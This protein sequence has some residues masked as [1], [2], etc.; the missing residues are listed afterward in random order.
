MPGEYRARCRT[1]L[2]PV[3]F[4][5]RVRCTRPLAC[6]MHAARGEANGP[7][8]RVDGPPFRADATAALQ[9][10]IPHWDRARSVLRRLSQAG[11]AE[12]I[13]AWQAL[14]RNTQ[15]QGRSSSG[16]CIRD[17]GE[18]AVARSG[19]RRTTRC[20]SCKS[21]LT[22]AKQSDEAGVRHRLDA[23]LRMA[24]PRRVAGAGVDE[25]PRDREGH[26]RHRALRGDPAEAVPDIAASPSRLRK[27]HRRRTAHRPA[28]A[29]YSTSSSPRASNQSRC[30]QAREPEGYGPAS[31]NFSPVCL[32]WSGVRSSLLWSRRR[33][34]G[35]GAGDE[36]DEEFAVG[37]LGFTLLSSTGSCIHGSPSSTIRSSV[38][39]P[40]SPVAVCLRSAR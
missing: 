16:P 7:A 30:R 11:V 36:D 20:W 26:S 12:A 3:A 17:P 8:L 5:M 28:T 21:Y 34:Q 33:L 25:G 23:T 39:T 6:Q 40:A 14:P 19:G 10:L 18:P 2:M 24:C 35:V 9:Y 22:S 15:I 32:A 37:P 13:A 27:A 29:T 4:A 1:S 38:A 31:V